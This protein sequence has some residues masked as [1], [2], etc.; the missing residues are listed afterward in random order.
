MLANFTV[1]FLLAVSGAAKLRDRTATADAFR[2]LR[3]PAWLGAVRAPAILPWA[4]L[5]LAGLLLF[6]RGWLLVLAAAAALGLML[7]YTAVIARALGFDEPVR[8]SCF[9]ALGAGAVDRRT[10]IRN[11]VLSV[12]AALGVAA[13]GLGVT[14]YG[15]P[16]TAL[17]WVALAA[18]AAAALAL[19]LGG[20]EPRAVPTGPKSWTR[21]A[22]LREDATGK[23][24]RVADLASTHSGATLVFLLPGCGSCEHF[25]SELPRLR[26]EHPKR[27]IVPVLPEWAAADAYAGTV[28]L[29]RDPG[30]NLAAAL[31]M[32]FAPAALEVG[33]D[34]AAPGDLVIGGA[35][36]LALLGDAV[37]PE[38][39]PEP[40]AEPDQPTELDYVRRPIPDAVL[41]DREGA[42]HT[43][44]ELTALRPLL[45]VSVD[46]LCVEPRRA[47]ETLPAWQEA[48]PILDVRLVVQFRP[49]AGRL[50][51]QQEAITFYDHTGIASRSLRM[52]G[53][54]SAV[55][56]GADGLLAGG[57]VSGYDEVAA[58]VEEIAAEIAAA[59]SV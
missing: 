14:W 54:L 6:A 22:T 1:G 45:L 55:L 26:E 21:D 50:T 33:P 16:L 57:P 5:L 35:A 38:P 29:H 24:V 53:Q 3:L 34:G 56:L 20:G 40:E 11:V 47:L 9:G 23:L 17:G 37:E 27:F 10:L 7:A 43:L 13:A 19:S 51:P 44:R 58:F 59:S 2:A 12:L 25:M 52:M 49:A 30:S 36:V 46:C 31:G 42:P 4:E 48:L 32:T 39:E 28:D 18:L 8:C 15:R 41:L